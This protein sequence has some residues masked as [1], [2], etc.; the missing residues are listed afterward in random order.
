MVEKGT[1]GLHKPNGSQLSQ[2]NP[3]PWHYVAG[4]HLYTWVEKEKMG[5]KVSSLR[6]Q[7]NG[8]D[9]VWATNL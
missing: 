6:K 7:R 2:L 8:K 3:V 9:Q 4:T 1:V 5:S